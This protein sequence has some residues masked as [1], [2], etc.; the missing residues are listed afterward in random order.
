M[1]EGGL[2]KE[3]EQNKQTNNPYLFPTRK[4]ENCMFPSIQRKY[5]L[6]HLSYT[7]HSQRKCMNLWD[8]FNV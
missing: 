5:L 3:Q 6:P 4:K 2:W 8:N 7:P 1:E